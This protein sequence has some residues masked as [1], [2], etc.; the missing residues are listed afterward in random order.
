M[1]GFIFPEICLICAENKGYV[2]DKCLK[3][4]PRP[5]FKCFRCNRKNPFGLYCAS[6]RENNL[7]DMILAGFAYQGKL[8]D[9]IHQYKFEDAYQLSED[10]SKSLIPIVKGIKNYKRYVLT[11]VPLSWSRE[12]YRGY[13]QSRLLADKIARCLKMQVLD[14]LERKGQ[15][16][17]QVTSKTKLARRRNIKG[18]FSIKEDIDIPENIVLIDD[19]V[20][21]GATVEETTKVLKQAGA[22]K[23][24]VVALAMGAI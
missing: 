4:L 3:T 6:C 23:V 15:D 13:N 2:C 17:T 24:A 12:R 5:C 21:T 10:F 18:V 14:L 19:V 1:L 11:F 9:A 7:P 20:T 8:K 22:K 16:E